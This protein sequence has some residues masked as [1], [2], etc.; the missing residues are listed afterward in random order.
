M[1]ADKL[2][3]WRNYNLGAS[4][5]KAFE[6]LEAL[7]PDAPCGRHEID[8]SDVVATISEYTTR[9]VSPDFLETHRKFADIQMTIG[10]AEGLGWTI[11]RE[12]PVRT[13]YDEKKDCEF[14]EVPDQPLT[15]LEIDHGT[16]AVFFPDDAHIGKV[17]PS[18][19]AGPVKK[20]VV[21]VAMETLNK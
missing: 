8:G 1:I 13:A 14:L 7:R 10:G 2:S 19:G 3:N 5:A 17:A 21:K 12:L 15:W 9:D 16:F 18:T 11:N 20:V 4:F 6:Y